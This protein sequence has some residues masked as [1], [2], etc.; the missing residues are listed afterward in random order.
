MFCFKCGKKIEDTEQV[1]PFC[2]VQQRR[3]QVVQPVPVVEEPVAPVPDKA[4]KS[5]MDEPQAEEAKA[6]AVPKK[7]GRRIL[8]VIIIIV[9]ILGGAVGV[10]IGAT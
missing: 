9:I 4:P 6:P 5:V 7:H 3:R 2:G 1:C 8:A 10:F